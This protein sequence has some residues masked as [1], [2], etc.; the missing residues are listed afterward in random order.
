[1]TTAAEDLDIVRRAYAKQVMAAA[2]LDARLRHV[3][4]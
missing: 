3:A 2:A 1:V 4:E